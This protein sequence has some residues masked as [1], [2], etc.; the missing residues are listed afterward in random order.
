M[1]S[2]KALLHICDAPCHGKR[3]SSNVTDDHPAGDPNNLKINDLLTNISK[4]GILYFFTEINSLTEIMIQEFNKELDQ[5]DKS[6]QIRVFKLNSADDLTEVFASSVTLTIENTRSLTLNSNPNAGDLKDKI[7]DKNNLN[8]EK[9]N[10]K[11]HDAEILGFEFEGNM[12]TFKELMKKYINKDSD[13]K[14]ENYF[15]INRENTQ[16]FLCGKPFAKGNNLKF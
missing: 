5:I 2:S 15:K 1:N 11:E 10:L 14:L 9:A 6:S 8:F 12:D 4:R 3:F 7:V 16:V 13:K